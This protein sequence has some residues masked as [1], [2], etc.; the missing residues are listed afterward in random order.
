MKKLKITILVA[1]FFGVLSF[2]L[3]SADITKPEKKLRHIVAFKFKPE[4]SLEQM[5]KATED[6]YALKKK[7]PQIMEFEG[8]TDLYFKKKK[9]E[10]THCFIVTVKNEEDLAAYGVHPDHKAFSESVDP[11]LAEVM[12][13][14][15][16]EE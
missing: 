5:Q 1:M 14:D 10:F 2:L 3:I 4:V 8:G 13:V 6:F 7:V 12:V 16:W 9:G 15:Y 11:L